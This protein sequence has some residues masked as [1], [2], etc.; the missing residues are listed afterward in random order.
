MPEV[1]VVSPLRTGMEATRNCA[2][3]LYHLCQEVERGRTRARNFRTGIRSGT[4]PLLAAREQTFC[5]SAGHGCRTGKARE[6]KV[7]CEARL[8]KHLVTGYCTSKRLLPSCRVVSAED[9]KEASRYELSFEIDSPLRDY[10]AAA[11]LRGAAAPE[12]S[13]A[14]ADGVFAICITL[15]RGPGS[16]SAAWRALVSVCLLVQ[17][18]LQVPGAQR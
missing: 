13:L 3:S 6:Q 16:A 1:L 18:L 4:A 14:F 7:R 11:Q 15:L 2:A 8:V 9:L 17:A 12:R 10:P 5:N